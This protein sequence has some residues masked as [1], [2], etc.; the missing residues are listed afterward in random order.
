MHHSTHQNKFTK[1]HFGA[2]SQGLD[3]VSMRVWID[4][5]SM[6]VLYRQEQR[7]QRMGKEAA[8][9]QAL[10]VTGLSQPRGKGTHLAAQ[11]GTINARPSSCAVVMADKQLSGQSTRHVLLCVMFCQMRRHQQDCEF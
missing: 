8:V 1:V 5:D 2:T 11:R 6:A 7:V 10:A 4:S 9:H 3:K